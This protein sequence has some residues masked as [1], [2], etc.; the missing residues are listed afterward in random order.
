MFEHFTKMALKALFKF[1][2]HSVISL[3]SLVFG[4]I[5]F[6]SATLLSNYVNSYEKAF[7]NSE[8][9]FNINQMAT[10]EDFPFQNWPIVNE[11]AARYLRTAFP[12]LQYAV[13]A[14]M[15]A[16][17]DIT[18]EG[19]VETFNVRYVEPEYFGMFP[20]PLLN[21]GAVSSPGSLPPNTALITE[22]AALKRFGTTDVVGR[23]LTVNNKVD[24]SIAGVIAKLDFPSHLDSPIPMFTTEMFADI[25]VYDTMYETGESRRTTD[26]SKEQW[27]NNS[28][29]VFVE[30]PPGTRVDVDQFNHR[31]DEFV[32]TYMPS[33]Y[34][35]NMTYALNPVRNLTTSMF[36]IL[37]QGFN[38]ISVLQVAGALV[39]LIGC[40]NYSN[41]VIAQLSLRSQEIA[42]QKILG[43]KRGLLILQYCYESLLFVALAMLIT[44]A[45]FAVA[46]PMLGKAVAGVGPAMLLSP[47]L[48]G[49]LLGVLAVI[50]AIA[51]FYPALRTATVRL[52]TMMR[53]KGS[54]GYS[55][56]MRSVMVGTQFF[57]SGTL[58]IVTIVMYNQ[59][60]AMTDQLDGDVAD[61]KIVVTVPMDSIDADPELLMNQL[62]LNP[63]VLSVTRMDRQPWEIGNSTISMSVDPDINATTINI[64]NHYVGYDFAETMDIPQLAGRMFSRE[65]SSDL[66]PSSSDLFSHSGPFGLIVDDVAAQSLGFANADAAIG[67]TVYRHIGPPSVDNEIVVDMNI[68]GAVG[69]QKFQFIDFNTFGIGGDVYTLRPT[70]ANF[71]II[72]ASKNNLNDTLRY[73]DETWGELM[74][75]TPIK[76]VFA[77]DLFYE[78][79]SLFLG[80]ATAI[81]ALSVFGFFIASIGLLGNA[82]FITNIRQKEVGIRKVMGASTKR[83]LAMLLFDFAKPVIV[84]NALAI[85][86]GY[87]IASGYISLFATRT[88][89]TVM[90]F[91]ISFGLSVLIA[92]SAVISQSWKSARVR[93]ALTLRYE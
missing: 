28:Y 74:P 76:R 67:Q 66:F 45:G 63:G 42:V 38:L 78:T 32:Q 5:C 33:D 2:L 23:T 51:G 68:I 11:P 48:W 43:A 89:I 21:S 92:V 14:T 56:R 13:R 55:G 93:P 12:E 4:F 79:Y 84:A 44:L 35:E 46:L 18:Y 82:T 85:P 91:L 62:K 80:I 27:G 50:V 86:L 70:N 61:P 24:I 17:S 90:P 25:G 58:M 8:N 75:D 73:V 83:L 22:S 77:D 64:G 65:R 41:L 6:I 3:I 29:Y 81:G 7:P 49:S 53:P 40:L 47:S 87:I 72:R 16:P 20:V 26:P 36:S 88:E 1:K 54:S 60:V 37:T 39:L 59:N 10:S 15:P 69:K 30:F 71:L 31:L 34:S 52:V 57:I 9:I 19:K